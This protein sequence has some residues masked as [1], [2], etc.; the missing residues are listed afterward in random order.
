MGKGAVAADGSSFEDK[1]STHGR[2]ARRLPEP[3]SAATV[4]NLGG[5]AEDPFKI[6]SESGKV[7]DARREELREW[8]RTQRER[9]KTWRSEHKELSRKLDLFLSGKVPEMDYKGLEIKPD[10]ATRAA[11][12]PVL[13]FY[14]ERIENMI[15]A[16]ADLCNSDKTDGY[17][18]KTKAFSKG[19]FSGK[20]FQAGVS[21]LT[22]ACIANG[23]A[24]HGGVI[25]ACGTFFVFSDYMKPAVRL[26][27]LM[28]LHVIYICDARLVPCGR[29]RSDAPARRARG[30]DPSDG[31][32]EAFT[33]GSVLCWCCVRPTAR[34][35]SQPGNW[36]SRSI[37]P[38]R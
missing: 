17:L 9:E 8:V 37:V 22:M 32:F 38:S 24:L 21:E 33:G 29:G 1:V 10:G 2:P 23:M 36:R 19:D 16:S 31:T 5:D 20:F 34:K 28:H 27:A 26:A 35:P 25:P 7:F 18:K 30:S 14:A 4:R 3:I 11:S 13:S 6:F 12:A 15:V